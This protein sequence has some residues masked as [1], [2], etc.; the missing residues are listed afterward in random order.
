[1]ILVVC[2]THSIRN[3]YFPLGILMLMAGFIGRFAIVK[4]LGIFPLQ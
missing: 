2:L 3:T 4:D 1:M